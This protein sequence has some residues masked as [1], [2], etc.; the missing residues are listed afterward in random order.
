M[1][2]ALKGAGNFTSS[3]VLCHVELVSAF[4]LLLRLVEIPDQVQHD[5]TVF[6]ETYF[7]QNGQIVETIFPK[8]SNTAS[9]PAEPGVYLSAIIGSDPF[10]KTL[11]L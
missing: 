7:G 9:P 5:K 1:L 6:L 11:S 8:M 2:G 4:H 10:W 3:H